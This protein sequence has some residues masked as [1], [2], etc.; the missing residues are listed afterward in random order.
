MLGSYGPSTNGKPHSR[1]FHT[2]E[3]PT[4]MLA[5]SGT[6]NVRSQFIDDDADSYIGACFFLELDTV[7]GAY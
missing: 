5:R 4:G 1:V 7:C 2:E 6:Y 3:S